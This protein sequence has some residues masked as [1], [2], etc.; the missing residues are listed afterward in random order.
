MT[1][2]VSLHNI[3]DNMRLCP[4]P[5]LSRGTTVHGGSQYSRSETVKMA[6]T[7]LGR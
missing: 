5:D 6:A 1:Y 3:I 7:R 4:L 2:A